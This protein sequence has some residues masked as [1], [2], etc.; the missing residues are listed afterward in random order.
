MP[1]IPEMDERL[2]ED[3]MATRKSA[4]DGVCNRMNLTNVEDMFAD[5]A[6]GGVLHHLIVDDVDHA[7]YCYIPKVS[8]ITL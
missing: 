5:R 4:I 1:E 6:D 7:I 8:K 3:R 2:P